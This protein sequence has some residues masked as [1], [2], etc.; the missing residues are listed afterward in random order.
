ML[1]L[2]LVL[3]VI[4]AIAAFFTRPDESK[5]RQAAND[6]LSNPETISQGIESMGVTLVGD[7]AFSDYYVVTRYVVTLDNRAVV[8]CWGAFT[9]TQCKRAEPASA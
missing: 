8:S 6:T 9:Q 7:R 2:V 4:A 3:V 5:L 1:R